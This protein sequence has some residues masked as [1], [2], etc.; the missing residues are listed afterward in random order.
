MGAF[1]DLLASRKTF[2]ENDRV[3]RALEKYSAQMGDPDLPSGFGEQDEVQS[4]AVYE[5]TVSGGDFT[6]EFTLANG[7]TFTTAAIAYDANAAAIESAIDTAAT[8]ASIT[9]WT[10]GDITVAGGTL[11][12]TPVTFTFD[13]D[14]VTAQNHALIVVDDAGLTGGGT[15]GAVTQTTVGQHARNA[16]GVMKLLGVLSDSAPPAPGAETPVTAGANLLRV[17]AWLIQELAQEAA[18]EDAERASYTAVMDA[19]FGQ[20][21]APLVLP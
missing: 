3:Y 2:A 11:D 15:A 8:T 12:S 7:E 17:P 13:G 19:V 14:S 4:L 1:S 6:L 5:G 21:S 10:N 18:F 9:G 16:F 20:D